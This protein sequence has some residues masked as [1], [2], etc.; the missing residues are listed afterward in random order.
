[1]TADRESHMMPMPWPIRTWRRARI[2]IADWRED[3]RFAWAVYTALRQMPRGF[4][5]RRI[6]RCSEGWVAEGALPESGLEFQGVHADVY[7]AIRRMSLR[8]QFERDAQ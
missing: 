3:E 6:E 7:I 2:A 4:L 1:M 5:L 8:A